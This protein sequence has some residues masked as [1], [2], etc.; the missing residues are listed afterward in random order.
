[1][2]NEQ[3][4]RQASDRITCMLSTINRPFLTIFSLALIAQ[5]H[6]DHFVDY[7]WLNQ[8][9]ISIITLNKTK[10]LNIG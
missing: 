9:A 6:C 8:E 2:K 3:G 7:D 10:S 5:S 4:Q 1:M